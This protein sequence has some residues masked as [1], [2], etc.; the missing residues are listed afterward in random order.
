VAV[1]DVVALMLPAVGIAIVA[2]SD[3]VLTARAFATSDGEEIDANAELRALS[4]ANVGVGL[5]QGFP[6]SSSGS[7]TALGDAVGSRTQLYSMVAVVS[8]LTVVL[9]GRNVLAHFPIAALGALVVYAATRLIDKFDL[10]YP[11]NPHL[12]T[13]LDQVLTDSRWDMTYL[14]MQVLIEGLAL[15]AFAS[16]R[17]NSQNPLAASVNAYVMQDEARHVAF[18]R[19]ALRDFYPTLTQAER[20]E[21]EEFAVE[22]CYLMRDR[23]QAEEVWARLGLP[24]DGCAR[25]MY[26]SRFM[27]GFRS[28]L[29]SRIV[30]TMKDIGLWGPKIRKAYEEMGI[31]GYADTDVQALSNADERVAEEFDA[32]RAE[33]DAVVRAAGE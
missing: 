3:N 15:A 23:F 30:P 27:S 1:S 22:A 11:I 6:V 5:T 24:V 13:L 16:I 31:L 29:F 12:K 18:G 9:W 14:G 26:E 10:V 25:H 32:R 21:R 7:R 2:F 8:V 28:A 19:F 20:D 17:D 33:V 4:V